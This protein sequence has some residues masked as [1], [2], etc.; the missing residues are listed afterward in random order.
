M[1]N[2]DSDINSGDPEIIGKEFL[3][4]F[5]RLGGLRSIDNVLDVGAG[6]GRMAIPLTSFL[7]PKSRYEGIEIIPKG[8]EWCLKNIT[9]KFQNFNF[10]VIDVKND[11]YNPNGNLK[12][13]EFK[14]P[15]DDELFDFIYLTSVFTHM[16]PLDLENYLSE[17]SRVLRKGGR[18]LITY[19]LLNEEAENLINSGR[20]IHKLAHKYENCRVEHEERPEDVVAYEETEIRALYEK[21][22]LSYSSVHYGNWCG[23][24]D[25]VSHQDIVIGIKS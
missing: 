15:F 17:I 14:F 9:P 20:S 21:F 5:T 8:V 10:Q 24:K 11:T 1:P 25:H 6:Y 22:N 4:H 2:P 13:S 7:S 18:T 3:N 23:R 16:L 12:A 19:F